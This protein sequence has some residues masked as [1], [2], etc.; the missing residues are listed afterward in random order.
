MNM[1]KSPKIGDV[2][3]I[4]TFTRYGWMLT[5]VAQTRRFQ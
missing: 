1:P 5:D 2:H 3:G 4:F